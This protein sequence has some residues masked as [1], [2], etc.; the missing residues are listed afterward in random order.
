MAEYSE[1]LCD[2]KHN[3]V[4]EKLS[5]HEKRLNDHG[6]RIKKLE[7]DSVGTKK[8][9]ELFKETLVE[10]KNLIEK[11][12]RQLDELKQKPAKRWDGLIDKAITVLVGIIIGKFLS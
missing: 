10:I 6:D 2:E 5:L 12:T 7:T 3:T 8:D 11:M 4:D 9:V 1:K